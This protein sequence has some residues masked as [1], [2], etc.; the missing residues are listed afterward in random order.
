MGNTRWYLKFDDFK[1]ILFL[2][3]IQKRHGNGRNAIQERSKIMGCKTFY[4]P[5]FFVL[6]CL[7]SSGVK[8]IKHL[9]ER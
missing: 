4:I 1:Q 3:Q 7:Y 8:P 5:L 2:S 6:K 9:N